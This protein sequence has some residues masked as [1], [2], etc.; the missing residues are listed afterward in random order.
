[1]L[2]RLEVVKVHSVVDVIRV[3]MKMGLQD[4]PVGGVRDGQIPKDHRVA[5]R[6]K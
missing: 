5:S 4:G 1:M 3:R 6:Q 2:T